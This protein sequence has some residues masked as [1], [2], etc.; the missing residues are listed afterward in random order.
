MAT[1][2]EIPIEDQTLASFQQRMILDD[3]EVMLRFDWNDREAIWYLSFYDTTESPL[4][5]GLAMPVNTE[6]RSRFQI[7]GLPPGGFILYDT[8]QKNMDAGSED[9][10]NRCRLYYQSQTV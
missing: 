4:L 5:I 6:I 2:I 9:L 7:V 10:G 3:V 1:W 8:S